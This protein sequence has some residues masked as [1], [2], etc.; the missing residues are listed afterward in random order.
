M[1]EKIMKAIEHTPKNS[2]IIFHFTIGTPDVEI[3]KVLATYS[4]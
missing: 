1:N 2:K 4:K 3:N